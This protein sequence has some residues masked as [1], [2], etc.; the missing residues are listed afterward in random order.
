MSKGIY[1]L[2]YSNS[3]ALIIGINDY[4]HINKLFY[5]KN[6]AE[7]VANVLETNFEFPE[8]NIIRLLDQDATK[9]NIMKEMARFANDTI[10]ENDRLIVYFAGHGHTIKGSKGDIGYLVPVDAVPG[11][12]SSLIKWKEFMAIVELIPAKHVFFIFDACFS[13]LALKRSM[14]IGSTRYVNSMLG[15]YSVQVLTSGKADEIVDDANGPISDHSIFTGHLI[16]GLLGDDVMSDGVLSATNLSHYVHK[17]VSFDANSSQTPH[18]GYY[19]GD[20]DFIFRG[21]GDEASED[22]QIQTLLIQYDVDGISIQEQSDENMIDVIKEMVSEEK[23]RLKLDTLVNKEIKLFLDY[24]SKE[25]MPIQSHGDKESYI[26]RIKQYEDITINLLQILI[27]I[28]HW[29]NEKHLP[30]IKKIITRTTDNNQP[31]SG[32]T[33][34]LELRWYP[35]LLLLYAGGL[36]ALASENYKMLAYLFQQITVSN[37]TLRRQ[38]FFLKAVIKASTDIQFNIIDGFER[39]KYPKSEYLLL[40]LQPMIDNVLF[41]GRD[42]EHIFDQFE[43]FC[44]LQYVFL[45]KDTGSFWGPPGRFVYKFNDAF[46]DSNPYSQVLID[47]EVNKENWAPLKAGMFSGSYETLNSISTSFTNIISRWN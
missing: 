9:T 21:Y 31:E 11:D 36:A 27:V 40:Q 1:K 33:A 42:Y 15:R 30:I 35:S 44:A 5:A 19:D 13:G 28:C 23:Y 7:E 8:E 3:W 34:F 25:N 22:T 12:I 45:R 6:D 20:G 24:T 39:K 4:Q 47:A 46:G 37:N 38:D 26:E 16:N 29:G 10:K 41:L 14:G 32:S 43:V 18:Y 17:K 2:E